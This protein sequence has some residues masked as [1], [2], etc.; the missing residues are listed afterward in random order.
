[1]IVTSG[2]PRRIQ[3]VTPLLLLNGYSRIITEL[4]RLFAK[5]FTH[6]RELGN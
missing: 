2:V 6:G 5:I 3:K 1:M 4:F